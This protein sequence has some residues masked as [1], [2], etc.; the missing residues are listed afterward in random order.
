M[1]IHWR[2]P[3]QIP[4][5]AAQA[6]QISL[7]TIGAFVLTEENF[8]EWFQALK[9]DRVLTIRWNTVDGHVPL[10]EAPV[11][12]QDKMYELLRRVIGFSWSH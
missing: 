7:R 11:F 8:D 9:D 1:A 4:E 12:Y 6:Y 2:S 3:V 10:A 5:C